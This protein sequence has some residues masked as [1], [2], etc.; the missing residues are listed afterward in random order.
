MYSNFTLE[1][2]LATAFGRRVD[3]Q[4]GESDEFSKAM[5]EVSGSFVDGQFEQFVV[6]NSKQSW[7]N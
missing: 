4:R 3:L 7:S 5:N 1:S 2:I 6:F